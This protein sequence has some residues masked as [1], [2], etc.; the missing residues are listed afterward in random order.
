MT[1][2]EPTTRR[3]TRDEYYRL[4]GEGW[5]SGQRVQLINGEILQ[6]PPQGYPHAQAYLNTI[7]IVN[8]I[9]GSDFVRPQL[10]LNV[11]G[12]SDPE[13]DVAVTEYPKTHYRDHPATAA[14]IV[15]IADSS[16][17]LD[18]RKANLY[19]TAGVQDYWIV[20]L[21]TRRLEVFRNP[22]ADQSQDFGHRYAETFELSEAE[23]ISP[24]ARTEAKI[25]VKDLL[26]R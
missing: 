21:T 17:Y 5:F 15:E 2:L 11:P 13:P 9:F 10:P 12:D 23:V 26:D 4:A 18:R 8:K 6:M 25:Q 14:L 20:N 16:V 1:L 7:G 24:L 22:I 3:W 19:A